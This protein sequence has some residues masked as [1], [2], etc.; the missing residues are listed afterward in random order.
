MK[1]TW[2][3]TKGVAADDPL[4]TAHGKVFVLG[5]SE[6]HEESQMR[7]LVSRGAC[8]IV[9]SRD[10]VL[11]G[12]C[13]VGLQGGDHKGLYF[14]G[15][16][17]TLCDGMDRQTCYGLLLE[18]AKK[19]VSVCL[20]GASLVAPVNANSWFTYRLRTDD[21][22]ASYPWEPKTDPAMYQALVGAGFK[23]HLKYWSIGSRGLDQVLAHCT[24]F[25]HAAIK[26]NFRFVP[27]TDYSGQKSESLLR[28]IWQVSH[29]AFAKSPLFSPI[30][31][32]DFCQFYARGFDAVPRDLGRIL[33]A[34]DGTTAG[35]MWNF[36]AA[37]RSTM[38]F[39]SMAIDPKY[40]GQRL[41]DAILYEPVREALARGAKE[42]ISALVYRGNK[43]EFIARLG[44]T[45]WEHHYTTWIWQ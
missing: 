28:G 45:L 4:W 38:V 2:K 35:F 44:E 21:H 31:F 29:L 36:F 17:A 5:D 32:E 33:I 1:D 41:G 13:L 40:Q 16:F 23:E 7:S 18:A 42:Y 3:I 25:Y 11:L 22:H 37:D 14:A 26:N 15:F 39:K 30:S 10:G 34:P 9:A 19:H 12:R 20:D 43:S 8:L 6:R 24:S 27:F